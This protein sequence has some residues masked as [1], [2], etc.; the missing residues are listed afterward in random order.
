MRRHASPHGSRFHKISYAKLFPGIL[1]DAGRPCK[2]A[3]FRPHL[4]I[5][6]ESAMCQM[7]DL[8]PGPSFSLQGEQ[9]LG[10]LNPLRAYRP[11][12]TNRP[13]SSGKAAAPKLEEI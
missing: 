8:K 5:R 6:P 11:T 2:M 12:E 7:A 4:D 3:A 13:R 9:L 10:L 1:T